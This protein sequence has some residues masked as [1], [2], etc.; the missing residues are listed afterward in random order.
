MNVPF[1]FYVKKK[2]KVFQNSP[3]EIEKTHKKENVN[4]FLKA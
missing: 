2:T 1:S 3:K 4:A